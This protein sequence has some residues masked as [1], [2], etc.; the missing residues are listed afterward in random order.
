MMDATSGSTYSVSEPST[1]SPAPAVASLLPEDRRINPI[2]VSICIEMCIEYWMA[3]RT[4]I[5]KRALRVCTMQ[6]R[7]RLERLHWELAISNIL[8]DL[9]PRHQST[10]RLGFYVLKTGWSLPLQDRDT[11]FLQSLGQSRHC[12]TKTWVLAVFQLDFTAMLKGHSLDST[13][14]R[15]ICD[16]V[17]T[18]LDNQ[19]YLHV[20][21]TTA[22]ILEGRHRRSFLLRLAL[23]WRQLEV[24]WRSL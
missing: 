15:L 5:C 1:A 14:S 22:R 4:G 11:D 9:S 6:Y 23:K 19:L 13:T 8:D 20:L 17:Y 24:E 18:L 16:C 7:R 3:T 10:M 21:K 2:F 12:P